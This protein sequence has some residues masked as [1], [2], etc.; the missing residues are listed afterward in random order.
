MGS[1]KYLRPK[2]LKEAT[3]NLLAYKDARVLAGGTDLILQMER[4]K[5]AL[6][7]LIDLSFIPGIDGLEMK[8][9]FLSLGTM[10]SIQ[11]IHESTQVREEF[12]AIAEAAGN[13]GCWQVR[14]RAT[15]GGNLANAAPSAEM[16]PP[17]IA[18]GA[19]VKL[20][21]PDGDRLLPLEN[22]FKGPGVTDLQP[23]ELLVE[24][25]VPRPPA[26]RKMIYLRHSLRRSMD[27][28]LVNMAVCFD[29]DQN[30]TQNVRVVLG[31]VAPTPIRARKTEHL[32]EGKTL[33]QE[34]INQAAELAAGE[35]QPI[36]DVR[37]TADYRREIV[38]VLV[39]RSFRALIGG[40][41]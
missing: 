34:L 12:P 31:A 23:G 11:D 16:A 39:R 37:S 33:D 8:E 13:L 38:K 7:H 17:L 20:V 29:D 5:V 36:T 1:I 15:L 9:D 22:F 14:N 27:I 25:M 3:A 40:V 18:L 6:T 21:G 32:L 24:V 28:S 30:V 41:D 35:C 4:K 19:L 26:A 10:I 2:S